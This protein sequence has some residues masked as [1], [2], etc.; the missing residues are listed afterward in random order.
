MYANIAKELARRPFA[1]VELEGLPFPHL[2]E[3]GQ[4]LLTTSSEMVSKLRLLHDKI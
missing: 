2:D 1:L 3:D 4:V